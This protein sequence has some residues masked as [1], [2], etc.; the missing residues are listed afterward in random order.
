M[1]PCV[2]EECGMKDG[3]V[4]SI[5]MA[6]IVAYLLGIT[7]IGIWSVWRQKLTGDVYFLAGRALGWPMVGAALFASNISTIHLVGLAQDGYKRGLVVGNFEWM[8]TFTLILCA[9][10]CAILLP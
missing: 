10:L 2:K 7:F 3:S 9:G 6:V 1:Q 5:D 8:A 4:W